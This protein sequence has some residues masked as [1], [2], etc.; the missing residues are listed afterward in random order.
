M[1][2]NM[3]FT[4]LI[5]LAIVGVV[6]WAVGQLSQYLPGPLPVII[7]VFVVLIFCLWLLGWFSGGPIWHGHISPC[8]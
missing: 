7:R 6:C 2:V 3:P 1:D 5:G 8:G 4:F